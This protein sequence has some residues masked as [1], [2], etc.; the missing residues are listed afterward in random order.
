MTDKPDERVSIQNGDLTLNVHP[1]RV[2]LVREALRLELSIFDAVIEE[3]R[4]GLA[5]TDGD[6][7]C[8]L[9]D[10]VYSE[11]DP[12]LRSIMTDW[13]ITGDISAD[14]EDGIFVTHFLWIPPSVEAAVTDILSKTTLEIMPGSSPRLGAPN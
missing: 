5:F 2:N 1:D 4:L 10:I 3:D 6:D 9:L 8:I 14:E 13:I 11:A 12:A 7:V